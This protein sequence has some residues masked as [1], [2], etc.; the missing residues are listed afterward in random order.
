[1]PRCSPNLN[2][3]SKSWIRAAKRECLNK[4][5]F[6]GERHV[7]YVVEQYVEHRNKECPHKDLHCQP[8]EPDVPPP[9]DGPIKCRK[10]LGGL[11]KSYFRAAAQVR[12]KYETTA[13]P[14]GIQG[15]MPLPSMS[16]SPSSGKRNWEA[17]VSPLALQLDP[18]LEG[19]VARLVIERA[20]RRAWPR[21][22]GPVGV[23][24]F[25]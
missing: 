19:A 25:G 22:A 18:G 3:F 21:R 15:E 1:M 8:V 16:K 24:F 9:R 10:R 23:G 14:Q 4:I 17:D 5:I 13:V 7:R 2:S 20:A 11:L 6:F 12:L